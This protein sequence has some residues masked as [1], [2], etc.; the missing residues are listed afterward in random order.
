MHAMHQNPMKKHKPIDVDLFI[1]CRNLKDADFIGK[2]DPFVKASFVNDSYK[3]IQKL[4]KTEQIENELNPQF[5]KPISVQYLF[6]KKQ[7]VGFFVKDDDDGPGNSDDNLGK[8]YSALGS[9]GFM[10]V[11]NYDFDNLFSDGEKLIIFDLFP[12]SFLPF[13][14]LT[15]CI[16]H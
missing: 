4:G 1:R 10:N 16:C 2:S 9:F 12:D 3:E 7:V 14:F 6:N 5:A 11:T 8:T 15:R 13:Y